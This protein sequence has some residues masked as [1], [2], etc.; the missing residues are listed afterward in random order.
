MRQIEIYDTTL[1]DGAQSEGINYSVS[2]KLKII[3]KLDKL[4][5]HYIEAGWP[6]ANPVD[7]EVF[8]AIDYDSL[9]NAQI[10]A[11]G[12]TRKPNIDEKDDTV[13]NMLVKSKAK[14]ITIFGKSWDFQV[15]EALNTTLEE[16]LN[17]IKGSIAFLIENGKEVFFD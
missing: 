3:K 9:K 15:T 11:F 1:R 17:M 13:L 5:V 6:G 16:N 4:G 10:A 8:D 7:N 14:I 2:D 12:C